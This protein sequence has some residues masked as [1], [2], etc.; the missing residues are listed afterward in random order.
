MPYVFITGVSSGIGY[1]TTKLLLSHHYQVIGS[2]RKDADAKRLQ[3]EFGNGFHA[4]QMDVCRKAEVEQAVEEVKTLLQGAPLAA[5]I[6]NAGIAVFGPIL[7]LP[8]EQIQQQFEVNVLGLLRVTQAFLP[9][10]GAQA[11]FTGTPGRL[12]HISSVSGLI[13]T[14]FLSLYSASKF[15]V[16][17]ISDGLRR[18]LIIYGIPSISIQP[19]P[20]RSS[21]WDKT[22]GQEVPFLNTDYGPILENSQAEIEKIEAGANPT[23]KVAKVILKALTAKKPKTRYMVAKKAWL[24]RMVANLMPARWLDNATTS[25]FRSF[26]KY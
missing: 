22:S 7:H 3:Q 21:I 2:V 23:S 6:N 10:L 17:S 19:G 14:P 5:L 18:E 24:M 20:T 11:D 4:V 16:E 26:K 1:E 9:L 8:P 13:T 25:R 12:I 15:A